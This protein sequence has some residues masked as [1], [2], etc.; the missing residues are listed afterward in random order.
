VD[1]KDK[2]LNEQIF[3]G[4][5]TC[6]QHLKTTVSDGSAIAFT[7]AGTS[8]PLYPTWTILLQDLIN[9]AE[10]EG[11]VE[12]DELQELKGLVHDDPLELA[13]HL[14]DKFTRQPFRA[15]LASIFESKGK[16]TPCHDLLVRLSLKAIVTLNYDD[17]LESAFSAAD[18]A[19]PQSIRAQDRAQVVK[20]QQGGL[21]GSNKLPIL[22]WHGVPSDPEQMVFTGDDYNLF[23][24]NRDKV[25]FVEQLWRDHR[26]LVVGFSFSDPFLVRVAES[27][28]RTLPSDNR[29]F[30]LI[31][32][33]SGP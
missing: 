32:V 15:R 28:L 33:H 9:R 8:T 14:E 24:N 29:H 25:D 13:S 23:Y 26:L 16:A 22:H 4:N 20:W 5:T 6:F 11:L 1:L 2:V 21:F 19:A 10:N 17:G 3:P 27:V 30:A 18:S 12:K 7:G 31:G